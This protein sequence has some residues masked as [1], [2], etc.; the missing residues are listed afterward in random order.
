[1]NL[2]V[3]AGRTV[4]L[5][6]APLSGARDAVAPWGTVAG[7]VWLVPVA[8]NRNGVERVAT[9]FGLTG[10]EERLLVPLSAGRT[11]AEVAEA[12]R[13]SIH[14]ARSQLK[15]IQRYGPCS[16]APCPPSLAVLSTT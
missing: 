3:G 7:L 2:T 13:N 4:I 16:G 1:M 8:S 15:S 9:T 11:L 10:A 5:S 6:T 14:T 12:L